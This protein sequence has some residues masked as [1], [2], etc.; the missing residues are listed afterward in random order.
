MTWLSISGDKIG[1]RGLPDGV[2]W[3]VIEQDPQDARHLRVVSQDGKLVF[4]THDLGQHW[5]AAPP[6]MLPPLDTQETIM[7][8]QQQQPPGEPME[9]LTVFPGLTLA[10]IGAILGLGARLTLVHAEPDPV[11][12]RITLDEY[13]LRLSYGQYI[14]LLTAIDQ[15]RD[16]EAPESE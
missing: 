12:G 4:E 5:R 8:Y 1:T 16:R 6:D 3:G 7:I 13:Y 10:E 9:R 2:I 15:D 11:K 14:Q